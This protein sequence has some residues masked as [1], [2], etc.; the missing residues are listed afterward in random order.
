MS[1][2]NYKFAISMKKQ[3]KDIDISYSIKGNGETLVL[4]H[5][6]LHSSKMWEEYEKEWI[7]NYQVITIDLP[8]HGKSG[9]VNNISIVEMAGILNSILEEENINKVTI[10]GHSLGG[11]VGLA[12]TELFPYKLDKLILLHSS[13]YADTD[14]VKKKRNLWLKIID[15]H[16]SMFVKNVIE[17]LYTKESLVKHKVIID[18]DIEDAK[19]IGYLGYI[20]AIKAMRDRPD[21]IRMLK[22]NKVYIIAGL[23]D[24][25]IE[26]ETSKKQ[27]ALLINGEGSFL[28]NSA[29]MGFIEEK[30]NCLFQ[31]NQYLNVR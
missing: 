18:K 29:H 6:F 3:F 13:A 25:V 30:E 31:I 14:L 24:K 16:P 7:K 28:K 27:F 2:N 10:I 12:F 17:Y 1:K 5:G 11:Y 26:K 15:K 19:K 23:H 4:L 9:V 21:R 22:E 20:E 8:G